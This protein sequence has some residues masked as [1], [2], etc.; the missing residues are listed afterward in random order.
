MF[1]HRFWALGSATAM[2]LFLGS[3][4]FA[5]PTVTEATLVV[6]GGE[7]FLQPAAGSVMTRA[8]QV[9]QIVA[10]GETTAV[11]AGDTLQLSPDA[12]AQLRF[13]D[14]STVDLSEGALLHVTELVDT[15]ESFRVRLYLFT[16]RTVSRVVHLLDADDAFVIGTPSSTTSVRG[17][18]FSVRSIDEGSSEIICDE[19]LVLVTT[20]D[21]SIEVPAGFHLWVES[22]QPLEIEPNGRQDLTAPVA[23]MAGGMRTGKAVPHDVAPC[24]LERAGCAGLEETVMAAPADAPTPVARWLEPGRS[25]TPL[26]LAAEPEESEA[27]PTA[28]LDAV[29]AP[30]AV[31]PPP[32]NAAVDSAPPENPPPVDVA[33]PAGEA[34]AGEAPPAEKPANEGVGN[35]CQGSS[36]EEILPDPACSGPAA[37]SNPHCNQP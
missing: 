7:V 18:V 30:A 25:I 14:G 28:V 35:E 6:T 4:L 13:L 33:P 10:T 29:S 20:P 3:F 8:R 1:R 34:P 11:K 9:E 32:D 12:T 22:G 19:G 24:L 17:T 21:G 16:G 26:P 37:A 15:D 5:S 36:C 2:I 27:A 23:G 31:V